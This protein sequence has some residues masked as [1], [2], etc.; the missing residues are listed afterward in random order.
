MDPCSPAEIKGLAFSDLR[1]TLALT[2]TSEEDQVFYGRGR[3]HEAVGAAFRTVE[4]VAGDDLVFFPVFEKDAFSAQDM[5]HFATVVVGMEADRGTGDEASSED[6]VGAVIEH[7]CGKFLLPSLEFRK[8]NK[9][10]LV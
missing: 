5:N 4:A 1:K 10:Y 8:V 2:D 6:A 9:R 7:V 3:I